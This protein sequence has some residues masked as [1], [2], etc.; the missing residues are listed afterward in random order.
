MFQMK[1]T[2]DHSLDNNPSQN[3]LNM[4]TTTTRWCSSQHCHLAARRLQVPCLDLRVSPRAVFM[5][6]L[7]VKS[8]EGKEE[9][10]L[11]LSQSEPVNDWQPV[12][13]MIG[14]R[15]DQTQSGSLEWRTSE[16]KR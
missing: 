10:R 14:W 1:Q 4:P 8:M 2:G 5:L 13:M 16:T 7:T 6:T 3:Q 12:M 9:L 11:S 15:N